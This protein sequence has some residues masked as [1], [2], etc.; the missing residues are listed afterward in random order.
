METSEK[1]ETSMW[2]IALPLSIIGI[3]AVTSAIVKNWNTSVAQEHPVVVDGKEIS[4]AVNVRHI[5]TTCA[6]QV[7]QQ[8]SGAIDIPKV[9]VYPSFVNWNIWKSPFDSVSLDGRLQPFLGNLDV[10]H[11]YLGAGHNGQKSSKC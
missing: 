11:D 6:V 4:T 2:P 9:K 5:E 3:T 10:L 7:S 1:L 8:E